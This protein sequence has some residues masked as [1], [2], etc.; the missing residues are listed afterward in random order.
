MTLI[1]IAVI[2]FSTILLVFCLAVQ[3]AGTETEGD[4]D[5]GNQDGIADVDGLADDG[6]DF[7]HFFEAF[8]NLL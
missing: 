6:F 2:L 1:A 5:E 8:K 7:D 4:V 3:A